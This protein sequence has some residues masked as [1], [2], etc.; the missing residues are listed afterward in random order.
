MIERVQ[1]MCGR[2]KPIAIGIGLAILIAAIL[3]WLPPSLSAQ[4]SATISASDIEYLGAF[5]LPAV[6]GGGNSTWD[7]S[8]GAIGYYPGGDA[9]GP[10]DSYPG[11]LFMSGHVY[12]SRVA[13]ID[14]PVPVKS[15]S[16][17]A[18]PTA[19]L[20]QNMVSVTSGLGGNGFIMGMAWIPSQSR[21]YFTHGQDYSDSDC[22]PS[23][24]PGLGSF[25][26]ALS[27]PQPQGLWFLSRNGSRLHPFQSLRW[28]MEVPQ[29]WA[30]SQLS[31]RSLVTGR[32]RGWC[33][34]GPSLYASAPWL[35]GNP[36]AAGSNIPVST[37]IHP[38]AYLDTAKYMQGHGYA[39]AYRGGV[40]LTTGSKAAAVVS[41]IL[42]FDPTRG[43]YGYEN[44]KSPNQCDPDPAANGCTGG[45]G[46]RAAD[47]RPALMLFNPTDL[48]AVASGARQSWDVDPYTIVDLESHML[49]SYQ[50]T[51]LATGATA[52]AILPTF[53]RARG[54]LYV[55]ES[56]AD[57]AKPVV[58]V[59]RVGSTNTS[60]MVPGAPQGVRIVP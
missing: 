32:Y 35:S 37:L 54:L 4:T 49:R 52:E 36:P 47:P 19:R 34:E 53:D 24:S 17:A 39:N 41:G 45:R 26:P 51:F 15:K 22:E 50:P 13:E 57:G 20:L 12:E 33:P 10:S 31:G 23:G 9:N 43:Y 59:F 46:W 8:N 58:H 7:Y 55:S 1:N 60:G 6:S 29:S 27:S 21:M 2:S 25:R 3:T 48:L 5:R 44:W 42:D 38:G 11:S 28:I 18:L 14:I 30:D 56:F 40:W 16:L